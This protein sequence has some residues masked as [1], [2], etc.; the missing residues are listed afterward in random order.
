MDEA[1]SELCSGDIDGEKSAFG[2]FRVLLAIVNM[3]T[4]FRDTSWFF[5]NFIK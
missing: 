2:W 4:I 5:F 1:P 3:P